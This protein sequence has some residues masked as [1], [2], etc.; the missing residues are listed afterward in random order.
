MSIRT[1]LNVLNRLNLRRNLSQTVFLLFFLVLLGVILSAPFGF[2]FQ[3]ELQTGLVLSTIWYWALY[4]P[5]PFQLP[6]IFL[7]GLVIELFRDGPPGVLLLWM[8]ATYGVANFW[9]SGLAQ[10]GFLHSLLAFCITILGEGLIEWSL[11]S[12]RALTLLSPLPLVFQ[13][14]LT[15]AAYFVLYGFFLWGRGDF[16]GPDHL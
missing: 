13:Y 10:G 7:G 4:K 14:V 11:M 3:G 16:E 6:A 12:L 5:N 9:R 2:L 8:L 1:G 15:L